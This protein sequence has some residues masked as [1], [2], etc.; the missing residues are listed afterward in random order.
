MK[1]LIAVALFV[2]WVYVAI[3]GDYPTA[4]WL[5]AVIVF[6]EVT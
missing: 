3:N 4:A 6:L 1:Q 2:C 5:A